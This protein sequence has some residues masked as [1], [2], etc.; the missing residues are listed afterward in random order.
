MANTGMSIEVRYLESE[1]EWL[2]EGMEDATED[3]RLS[4]VLT[5]FIKVKR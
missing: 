5:M 4:V 1:V 2:E 3:V